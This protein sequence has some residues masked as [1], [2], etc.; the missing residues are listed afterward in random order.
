M[1]QPRAQVVVELSHVD[2]HFVVWRWGVGTDLYIHIAEPAGP[3]GEQMTSETLVADTQ[4]FCSENNL[5]GTALKNFVVD[6]DERNGET[7]GQFLIGET[8]FGGLEFASGA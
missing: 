1:Q 2:R 6:G 8:A 4:P 7:F 3:I 5:L